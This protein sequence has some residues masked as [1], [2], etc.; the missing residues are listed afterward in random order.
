[1]FGSKKLKFQFL[2]H[3]SRLC[4]KI[5]LPSASLENALSGK[6]KIKKKSLA[7]VGKTKEIQPLQV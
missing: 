2:K 5:P 6:Q 7:T 4:R 1:M 3:F